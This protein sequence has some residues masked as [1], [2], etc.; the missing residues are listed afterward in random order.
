M[1]NGTVYGERLH[2][3]DVRFTKSVAVGRARL[4]GMV[5]LYN[6]LNDNTVL[7]Q[8]DTYGATTEAATGAAWLVPQGIMPGRVIK[9]GLQMNF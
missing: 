3:L 9:F 1:E 2:Q 7:V 5:D 4:Q 8:S 6:A